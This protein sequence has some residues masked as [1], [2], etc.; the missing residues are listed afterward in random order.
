MSDNSVRRLRR[1]SNLH[2]LASAALFIPAAGIA[3]PTATQ[4]AA[5]TQDSSTSQPADQNNEGV[6]TTRT[7][8]G[9]IIVTARHYVPQGAETATKSNIPLIQTPQ[10]IT[11]ITRDQIDLL[12]FTDAQQAVRYTA[13]V[14][15]ENYGPDPRYDFITVRGFT[16]KQYIDGLAVPATTTI[17]AVG[18]DL[19]GFQSLDILKGPSSVLYGAAPPGGI[20]NEVSRRASPIFGGEAEVKAGSDNFYEGAATVT[21][22]LA[23]MLDARATVLYR[24]TDGE[25]DYQKTKR[26][27]LAP[28]ATLKLGSKTRITGLFYYQ[29]DHNFGGN[30]GFLSA[31][32]RDAAA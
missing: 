22:P 19:Y 10:S 20:L 32:L 12:N 4:P 26:L 13:G 14:F 1:L 17:S 15:G 9:E 6:K 31:A 8:Q 23:P 25:I 21:G 28:T 16:P 24:N 30:G 27:L 29:Y 7:E 18:V 2:L 3:Q 11:V 5:T